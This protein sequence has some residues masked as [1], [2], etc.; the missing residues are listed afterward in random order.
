MEE[1]GKKGASV[2]G[3]FPFPVVFPD[4]PDDIIERG[5]GAWGKKGVT[6][7][8]VDFGV[9][10]MFLAK[11]PNKGRFADAGF[12][13]QHD[14]MAFPRRDFFEFVVERG[15]VSGSFDQFDVHRLLGCW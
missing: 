11:F 3:A 8:E 15:Q 12:A 2:I 4:L 7:A 1:I 10:A 5:Q 13:A 6:D 14:A 9:M